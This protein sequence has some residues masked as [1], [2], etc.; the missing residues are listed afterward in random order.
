MNI[1]SRVQGEIIKY[2]LE[3]TY[4]EKAFRLEDLR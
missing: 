3:E 1:V 2:H 4:K